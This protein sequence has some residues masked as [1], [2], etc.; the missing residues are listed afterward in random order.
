LK[1][2]VFYIGQSTISEKVLLFLGFL[3]SALLSVWEKQQNT[4]GVILTGENLSARMKSS[5]NVKFV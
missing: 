5:P 2:K 1:I 4:V 3:A